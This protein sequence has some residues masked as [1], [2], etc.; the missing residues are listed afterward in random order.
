[1]GPQAPDLTASHRLSR[2]WYSYTVGEHD[3][4]RR[5]IVR[6]QRH[7]QA[8]LAPWTRNGPSGQPDAKPPPQN[9]CKT[10]KAL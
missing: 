4:E 9:P 2:T 8:H 10:L 1:M 7:E 5:W 6:E 3:P